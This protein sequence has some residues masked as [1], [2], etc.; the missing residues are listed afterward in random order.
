MRGACARAQPVAAR[1]ATARCACKRAALPEC[2]PPPLPAHTCQQRFAPC[3]SDSNLAPASLPA[4]L[5]SGADRLDYVLMVVGTIGAMGNGVCCMRNDSMQLRNCIG[6]LAAARD[7]TCSRCASNTTLAP[8]TQPT[9]AAR[10]LSYSLVC[11]PIFA[12][13]FGTF[14]DTFGTAGVSWRGVAVT[15]IA[16]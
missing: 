1:A 16:L 5:L 3:C 11:W 14:A 15:L 10:L 4:Q 13:T 2:K 9:R 6:T 7:W 12:I 8:P